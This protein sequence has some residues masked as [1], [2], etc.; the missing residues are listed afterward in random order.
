MTP[1]SR[2]IS[3]LWLL[4]ARVKLV[5][6]FATVTVDPTTSFCVGAACDFER[7]KYFALHEA[8]WSGFW[9]TEQVEKYITEHGFSFG[10][11][12]VSSSIMAQMEY[13]NSHP[14]F[15]NQDSE[16][17]KAECES[18]GIEDLIIEQQQQQGLLT[19]TQALVSIPAEQRAVIW[20]GHA[21]AYYPPR[22]NSSSFVPGLLEP[23]EGFPDCSSIDNSSYSATTS[24]AAS[25]KWWA[26]FLQ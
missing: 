11:S 2:I 5:T 26:S 4:L 23:R 21:E 18:F 8:P 13:D 24:H 17:L 19:T 20:S 16:H 22:I 9:S 7:H 1:K 3:L 10:M 15:W 14:G 12:H 25:A 6:T